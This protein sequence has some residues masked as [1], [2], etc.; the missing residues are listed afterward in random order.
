MDTSVRPWR[1]FIAL[2]MPTP[3]ADMLEASLRPYAEAFPGA[4]W[5]R[6]DSFHVPLQFLGSTAPARIDGLVEGM[7][8]C[9][10]GRSAFLMATGRGDGVVR[11]SGGVCWL[12]VDGG[13][14]RAADLSACLRSTPAPGMATPP[15]PQPHVT[16]ARRAGALLIEALAGATLG[17]PSVEWLA[18]R[19]VLYRSHTGTPAGSSYE[20]L[21]SVPLGYPL[22][23]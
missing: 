8:A 15:T 21:A 14:E 3:S 6:P 11:A 1:L 4:R 16:V 19:M 20:A 12:R 23:A 2:P 9:A 18:D 10:L 13:R 22:A 7:R 5:Q 17:E